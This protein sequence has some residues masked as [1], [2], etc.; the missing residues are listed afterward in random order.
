MNMCE[1]VL[2]L[3]STVGAP[4]ESDD[5]DLAEK[6]VRVTSRKRHMLL[7]SKNYNHQIELE[8]LKQPGRGNG[9]LR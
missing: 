9:S 4:S 7:R 8:A 3:R 2:N 1:H 5:S 6:Q